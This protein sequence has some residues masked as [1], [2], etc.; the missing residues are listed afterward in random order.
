[1]ADQVA[2]KV[3]KVL[4][5]VPYADKIKSFSHPGETTI[6]FQVKDSAPP[7][8]VGNIFYT[9]R[10]RV[11][12]FRSQLLMGIQGPFFNDDFGD[13]YGVIYAMSA[14]GY[15]PKEIRDFVVNIRQSLLRVKDVGKV[16]IYGLQN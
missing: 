7:S 4:Q 13:T 8:E 2:D 6:L 9:V 10:K 16:E 1:M 3:E 14:K 15:S 5:E 11:N 12:D